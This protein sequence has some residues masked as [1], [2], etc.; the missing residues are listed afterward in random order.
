MYPFSKGF[1][2]VV[3]KSLLIFLLSFFSITANVQASAILDQ[4]P[5]VTSVSLRCGILLGAGGE[6]L[7]DHYFSIADNSSS[8]NIAVNSS[9]STAQSILSSNPNLAAVCIPAAGQST[10]PILIGCSDAAAGS[11]A[12]GRTGCVSIQYVITYVKA[13]NSME[14]LRDSL[15]YDPN[16]N[17][18]AS[19]STSIPANDLKTISINATSSDLAG[20]KTTLN[21]PSDVK[22]A[23]SLA[24]NVY[25]NSTGDCIGNAKYQGD[26]Y[27][28]S[29]SPAASSTVTTKQLGTYAI[30]GIPANSSG[31]LTFVAP[32]N[33]T[34]LRGTGC[35]SYTAPNETTTAIR[36]FNNIFNNFI[37]NR[38]DFYIA[39]VSK[40]SGK[41]VT[42]YDHNAAPDTYDT[43]NG[44]TTVTLTGCSQTIAPITTPSSGAYTF[45]NL[46]PCNDYRLSVSNVK[47]GYIMDY[48]SNAT[49]K[50]TQLINL[51]AGG[52]NY[53]ANNFYVTPL[54][55][56]SGNI[57]IDNN[58]DEKKGSDPNYTGATTPIT[59]SPTSLN[60][61]GSN[62]TAPTSSGAYSALVISGQYSVE[63]PAPLPTGYYRTY[64][65]NNPASFTVTVGNSAGPAAFRCSP[66]GHN[67][68]S[69]TSTPPA[70]TAITGSLQDVNFGISNS[71][72]WAQC[73]GAD[74]RR[75][76]GYINP[77]PD[78]AAAC[79]VAA[80][81]S[82]PLS[83]NP[84]VIFSG[85][86]NFSFC[87]G[88]AGACS[89][90]ISTTGWVVKGNDTNSE[91]FTP[92]YSGNLATSFS[93]LYSKIITRGGLTPTPLENV[94]TPSNCNLNAIPKGVYTTTSNVNINASNIPGN[95]NII[96][97]VGDINSLPTYK[98]VTIR[99]DIKV[100][101]TSTLTLSV[102]GDISIDGSV[103]V[104]ANSTA[105][106]V[107]GF[108]SADRDVIINSASAITCDNTNPDKRINFG[109]TVIANASF[110]GG[111]VKNNRNLCVN[112]KCPTIT[113]TE[114]PDFF[115]N[116]PETLKNK[117]LNWKEQ[118]P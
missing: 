72:P 84:G 79:P 85:N 17:L 89:S 64:P 48:D 44:G 110:T 62:V 30:N 74:C 5:P 83:T 28:T 47:A 14:G 7:V 39:A 49:K 100:P 111:S 97:L 4:S 33:Y 19:T 65:K 109:G 9:N 104:A 105:T 6:I 34:L 22:S 107:E 86:S 46:P 96:I 69:C 32:P 51:S 115:I 67:N 73:V 116:A 25:E 18:N 118:A 35:E 57:F 54:Y 13:D 95:R 99:G 113:F 71:Q 29:F 58:F 40:I 98:T 68:A 8:L 42:D 77:V 66:G 23:Y 12:S 11:T 59:I 94:C 45:D 37:N 3:S 93:A 53:I 114:R 1:F 2:S 38:T 102:R 24:G 60:A 92:R 26:N 87:P 103:G 101:T 106:S 10:I 56:I 108:Y 90:K 50:G 117:S 112:N 31:D 41:V 20:N 27:S 78:D 91:T 43:G 82:V 63:Y 75:D 15:T 16:L 70:D 88:G 80:F 52:T 36:T 61:G 81:A 55:R 76:S 21:L